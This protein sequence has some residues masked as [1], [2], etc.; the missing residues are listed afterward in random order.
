MKDFYRKYILD[1]LPEDQKSDAQKS[2][3]IRAKKYT[4]FFK[5][6]LDKIRSKIEEEKT[7]GNNFKSTAYKAL[8]I[9]YKTI[10]GLA[11]N[12]Q[13]LESDKGKRSFWGQVKSE[14]SIAKKALKV[15]SLIPKIAAET[16]VETFQFT[17]RNTIKQ[18]IMS[19]FHMGATINNARKYLTAK[20]KGNNE[21]AKIEADNIK[22]Q[23]KKSLKAA[24]ASIAIAAVDFAIF[25]SA[26]L[27]TPSFGAATASVGHF[28]EAAHISSLGKDTI[29]T[30]NHEIRS[31]APS[32]NSKQTDINALS[33]QK[34][35]DEVN[36]EKLQQSKNLEKHRESEKFAHHLR[37][38]LESHE[39]LDSVDSSRVMHSTEHLNEMNKTQQH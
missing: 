1:E 18:P 30:A 16:M 20:L 21:Q 10:T 19:V 34:T 13:A 7:K 8:A 14:P 6:P 3:E 24:L 11:I 27:A 36:I 26:G 37:N 33:I 15:F 5:A 17:I 32:E 31:R 4:D 22:Y 9:T 2:T 12:S 39:K 28:A 25:A 23:A 35:I 38:S 29:E